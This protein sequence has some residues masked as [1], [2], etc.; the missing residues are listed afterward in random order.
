MSKENKRPSQREKY[1]IRIACGT[2]LVLSVVSLCASLPRSD[3]SFDYLGLVTGIIA[4]CTTFIIGYQIYNAIELKSRMDAI[5]ED[6]EK[7]IQDLK[8]Q[9]AQAQDEAKEQ[10]AQVQEKTKEQ[11]T[12][13]KDEAK[14]YAR[15]YQN[16]M[17][18]NN[19]G[20]CFELHNAYR[21][22]FDTYAHALLVANELGEKHEA[23]YLSDKMIFLLEQGDVNLDTIPFYD[24]AYGPYKAEGKLL[25]MLRVRLRN[26]PPGDVQ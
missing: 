25:Q 8:E 7:K 13:A 20:V 6:Y 14:E 22:A 23:K 17:G 21:Q 3:L 4:L 5:A 24:L 1:G 15:K 10:I 11:I 16:L 19:L 2:A 9:I 12:R 18:Q 26:N